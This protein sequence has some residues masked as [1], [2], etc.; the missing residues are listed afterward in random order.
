MHVI[1]NRTT[2]A[3]IRENEDKRADISYPGDTSA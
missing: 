3:K 1:R 2:N